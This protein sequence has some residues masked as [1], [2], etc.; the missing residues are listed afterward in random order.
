M[1]KFLC[2][3]YKKNIYFLTPC[4]SG[5]KIHGPA[6]LA[7]ELG[8]GVGVNLGGGGDSPTGGRSIGD[9]GLPHSVVNGDNGQLCPEITKAFEGVRF[10]A[11]QTRRDEESNRVS[12]V[13]LVYLYTQCKISMLKIFF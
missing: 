4:R 11:E 6:V 12:L 3:K 7:D 2:L 1:F 5:C 8:V 9:M 10:I 13:V